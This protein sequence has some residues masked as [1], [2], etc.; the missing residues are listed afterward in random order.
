MNGGVCWWFNSSRRECFDEGLCVTIEPTTFMYTGGEEQ[1]YCVGFINYPRFP[2]SNNNIFE[3]AYKLANCL[4]E[5]TF[6]N[7]IL[8]MTPTSTEWISKKSINK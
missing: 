5:E 2:S 3:R 4:L 7:S 8:V 6:Q 1:G